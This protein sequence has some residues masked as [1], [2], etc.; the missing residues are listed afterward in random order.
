MIERCCGSDCLP[1]I[2][3][4]VSPIIVPL[5]TCG[6]INTE[7]L[8]CLPINGRIG[9][10]LEVLLVPSRH[11]VG[12][13]DFLLCVKRVNHR[14]DQHVVSEEVLAVIVPCLLVFLEIHEEGTHERIVVC[15]HLP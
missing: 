6:K 1:T 8:F 12:L 5:C 13:D 11:G 10:T 15:G 4:G 7:S 2:Q 14:A 9:L 3:K